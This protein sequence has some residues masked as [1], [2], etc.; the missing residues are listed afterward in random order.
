MGGDEGH[1]HT[2]HFGGVRGGYLIF[3]PPFVYYYS[4][5]NE[6]LT[7]VTKLGKLPPG[8]CQLCGS[9]KHW[10]WECPHYMVY[11]EGAKRNTN[12]VSALEP[13]EEDTMY[14]S[15]SQE[16]R[17]LRC[18]WGVVF[19]LAASKINI[20]RCKTAK[21]TAGSEAFSSSLSS[22]Q[23]LEKSGLAAID[24]L[25]VSS[26]M[27]RTHSVAPTVR[28]YR[29]LGTLDQKELKSSAKIPRMVEVEDDKEEE[30]KRK[31]KAKKGLLEFSQ[32][33]DRLVSEEP[34]SA[35]K[36][37]QSKRRAREAEWFSRMAQEFWLNDGQMFPESSDEGGRAS[38]SQIMRSI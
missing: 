18:S 4:E 22:P 14:H 27:F 29:I 36:D 24:S 25:P 21:S 33:E 13:S 15:S 19:E 7:K 28:D 26:E 32:P 31:P 6:G 8:L 23:G 20:S 16:Q 10:N 2:R 34:L 35:E 5:A 11:S 17:Q 12:L 37:W 38:Q 9:E 3:R 1:V 30:W